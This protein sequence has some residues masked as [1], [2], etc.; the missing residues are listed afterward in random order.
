MN[1]RDIMRAALEQLEHACQEIRTR[2]DKPRATLG[3][4]P[5]RAST[6]A[7]MIEELNRL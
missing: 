1:D 7:R 3:Q 5:H 2:I 6:Y 4:W